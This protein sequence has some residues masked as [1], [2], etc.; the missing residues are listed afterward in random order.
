MALKQLKLLFLIFGA[1]F[2]S[3]NSVLASL[4]I[5]S[6]AVTPTN[7]KTG[8][9]LDCSFKITGN[10][11]SYSVNVTWIKSGMPH[12]LD[13]ER[14]I[15]ALN[16]SAVSTSSVG[17]IE[18]EDTIKGQT[19]ACRV[20][21]SDGNENVETKTS[22]AVTIAD[23]APEIISTAIT[24][25]VAGKVYTYDVS[26][27]DADGDTLVYSLTSAPSGMSIDT[28]TGIISWTPTDSQTGANTVTLRVSDG[29]LSVEQS[30]SITVRVFRLVVLDISASC[31]PQNCDDDDLS[32][33]EAMDGNAG[34]IRNVAPGSTLTLKFR[35]KNEW[36]DGTR[37]HDIENVE[38]TCELED[39][40]KMDQQEESADFGDLN[41]DERSDR[42]ELVFDIPTDADEDT[43]DIDCTLEGEDEDGTDYSLD[44]SINVDV[45]KETHNVIFKSVS[46]NPSI[47]SCK[48][49]V[50]LTVEVQNTG[51]S[52]EKNL[53]LV[54]QN[55]QL[56]LFKSIFINQLKKDDGSNSVSR[57][58][59]RFSVPEKAIPGTYAIHLEVFYNDRDDS[60]IMDAILEVQ[61][62]QESIG[63][64]VTQ[65]TPQTTSPT[66]PIQEPLKERVEVIQQPY[67]PLQT[68]GQTISRPSTDKIQF[69]TYTFSLL[70][71]VAVLVVVLAF[72]IG[73]VTRKK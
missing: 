51:K 59:F 16:N 19:W 41:P 55:P 2:M 14:G 22:P 34:T 70:V 58:Q 49:D 46:L 28:S 73:K 44:F 32:E 47:V 36:P 53:E 18:P 48:R 68:T 61:K 65:Q 56:E 3:I 30:F 33:A 11:S 38:I 29:A 50:L 72:L 37:N 6:L 63:A 57:Q 24:T 64:N 23:S 12:T 42:V 35:V 15:I 25:A 39:I 40:G 10:M 66:T 54:V 1:L 21:A 8:D 20:T 26:A 5:D 31:E 9:T 52:T 67:I 60:N 69:D 17:D 4:S 43:Y 13:D 62:C 27:I 45:E 71:L 7:P